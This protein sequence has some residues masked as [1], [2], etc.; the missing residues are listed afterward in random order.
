MI[1][2]AKA[3]LNLNGNREDGIERLARALQM[4]GLTMEKKPIKIGSRNF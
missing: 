4:E 1:D 3:I 2:H